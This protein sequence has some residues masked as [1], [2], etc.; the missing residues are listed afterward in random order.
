[1]VLGTKDNVWKL[2]L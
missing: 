1:M 2:W